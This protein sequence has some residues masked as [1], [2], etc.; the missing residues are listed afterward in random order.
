MNNTDLVHSFLNPTPRQLTRGG[1]RGSN[2]FWERNA[3]GRVLYSYSKHWTLAAINDDDGR[4]LVNVD[5]RSVTTNRHQQLLLR[6]AREATKVFASETLL[7]A[8][9]SS[10]RT[11]AADPDCII[12]D[13][14]DFSASSPSMPA[15]EKD[16]WV[17]P[18]TW[19]G[20]A[21]WW[22]PD[23]E[24][25][26]TWHFHRAGSVV[27]RVADAD[28]LFSTDEG[29]YFGVQ[30]PRAVASVAEAFV[31]LRPEGWGTEPLPG[32]RRQ[33]E[34]FFAPATGVD[35][36]ILDRLR[37]RAALPNL[38]S[39]ATRHVANR[40]VPIADCPW[41]RPRCP[42]VVGYV[43]GKVYHQ[44][45]RAWRGPEHATVDLGDTWHVVAVN[46]AFRSL[47]LTR[48]GLGWD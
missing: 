26:G 17:A 29:Q 41:T 28:W 19:I 24:E 1:A 32:E 20:G 8:L 14:Q 13:A 48:F 30:L 21:R 46:R 27:I 10:V 25:S 38:D 35:V 36:K 23:S 9:G 15:V 33:G 42:Q 31:S 11:L 18:A 47:S 39:R 44:S 43:S 3:W 12:A 45:R 16:Q 7:N 34:W 22:V 6:A 40:F 5:R 2:L 4:V 37:R